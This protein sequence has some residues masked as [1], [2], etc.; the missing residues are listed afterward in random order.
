MGTLSF[1][2]T[3][4]GIE[5]VACKRGYQI[6]KRQVIGKQL[7]RVRQYVELFAITANGIDFDDA[8]RLPQLG[9]HYPVLYGAQIH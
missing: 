8:G 4:P 9:T 3:R 6:L 2:V 5:V 7:V 1:N